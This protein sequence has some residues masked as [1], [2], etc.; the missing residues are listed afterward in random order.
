MDIAVNWMG[1]NKVLERHLRGKFY[2]GLGTREASWKRQLKLYLNH[3]L[4][5]V[6][7]RMVWKRHIASDHGESKAHSEGQ[8]GMLIN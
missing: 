3:V 6:R 7:Y 4:N 1:E 2:A 8:H 5:Q